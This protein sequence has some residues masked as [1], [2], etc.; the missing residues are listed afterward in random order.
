MLVLETPSPI[1][2]WR[3]RFHI[4]L[5]KSEVIGLLPFMK[6]APKLGYIQN[7]RIAFFL[8]DLLNRHWRNLGLFNPHLPNP[9]IP[10][11]LGNEGVELGVVVEEIPWLVGS[12]VGFAVHLPCA[13]KPVP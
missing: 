12:L 4:F 2:S 7:L 8:G 9:L 11:H 3:A 10:N 5:R 13:I 6:D 1:F